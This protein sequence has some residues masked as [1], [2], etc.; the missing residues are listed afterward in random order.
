[1]E[2]F[3]GEEQDKQQNALAESFVKLARM[4]RHRA[5]IREDH[6]PGDVARPPIQLAIDEI[7]DAA[8]E[9]TDRDRLGDDVGEGKQQY[10]TSTGKQYDRK[11]HAECATVEGHPAVPYVKRLDRMIDIVSRLV[12]E[13]VSDP[14]SEHDAERRPYQEIVNI[15][16]R[17]QMRRPSGQSEAISPADQQPDNVGQRIP[18][19][20]KGSDRNCYRIDRGKRDHEEGHERARGD[21]RQT[22]DGSAS[23]KRGTPDR[24]ET[25]RTPPGG[26]PWWRADAAALTGRPDRRDTWRSS[27][28]RL[29]DDERYRPQALQWAASWS[30]PSRFPAS[31][32]A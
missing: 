12:E 3:G 26:A 32:P 21:V 13:N 17:D 18:T 29:P 25:R 31:I 8:K 1:M 22:G 9:E 5:A 30:P 11:G 23:Y 27:N 10:S 20:R 24:Q 16:A 2:P 7:G 28:C 6:R 14:P 4:S 19:D 15:L